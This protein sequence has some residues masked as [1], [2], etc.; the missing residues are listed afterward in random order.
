MKVLLTGA[1]GFIGRQALSILQ[2]KGI[3]VYPVSHAQTDL[4][5][6]DD[7]SA[8]FERVKPTHVLHFAW[9]A[10]PGV[11]WTSPLNEDW[12]DA[13]LHLLELSKQHG[14]ER[15]VSA[16]S[17]TEYDWSNGYCNE[18]TTPLHAATPYG[19]AK[20]E[21]GK[22]V[23]AESSLSTAWG[24][25]FYLYGPHEYPQRLVPSVIRSLLKNEPAKLTSGDQV[26]DFLHVYDVASAF[27]SLLESDLI[28]AMN[29]ASGLPVT[30]KEIA[31]CIARQM[32]KLELLEFGAL[33][34]NHTDPRAITASVDRLRQ[35]LGW[36]PSFGLEEGIANTIEWWKQQR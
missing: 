6:A 4:L 3:D 24:R 1:S 33:E 26:R 34:S 15:F 32:G 5:N 30:L 18:E 17:C 35:E 7:R 11:Y 14:V 16:G 12:K 25:I 8:L 22:I 27:V 10:T 21:T 20:A 36:A 2:E 31:E 28:G 19:Q 9:I 29:I 23:T 13:T